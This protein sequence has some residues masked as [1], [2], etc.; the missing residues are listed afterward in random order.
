MQDDNFSVL[1]VKDV[2]HNIKK[3]FQGE[4]ETLQEIR[5]TLMNDEKMEEDFVKLLEKHHDYLEESISVLIDAEA[6]SYEKQVQLERLVQVLNMH[7]KAEQETLY[8]S[9]IHAADRLARL[10]GLAG[11]D[12]HDVALQMA[13][14]LRKMNFQISWSEEIDA[15]AKVLAN[16]IQ[17]HINE[18][19]REMFDVAEAAIE[20]V[21]MRALASLYKEKCKMYFE[22]ALPIRPDP[23]IRDLL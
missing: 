19:E 7:A 23:I 21:K 17:S 13:N 12:E 10:E 6:S 18:E 3:T 5:Q 22:E 8:Q 16:L 15:K 9:L 14:E 2:L 1:G 11:Q 20:P 4:P